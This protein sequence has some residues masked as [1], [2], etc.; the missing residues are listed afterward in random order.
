MQTADQSESNSWQQT[1][2]SLGLTL[3]CQLN[4]DQDVICENIKH[5]LT[6]GLPEIWPCAN[7]IEERGEL[8][9]N[10]TNLVICAGGPS[11]LEHIDEIRDRQING[12][13]I[14]ALANVAHL[15]LAH[16]IRPNAHVL[17]DAKPRNADF[18]TNCETTLFI[19]S[20]CDPKVFE[21]ALKTDNQVMLYHAVNNAQEADTLN[22]H[23]QQKADET[24]DPQ[25]GVWVPVQGGSTITMRAIRLFTLLGYSK[26]HMYGWDSCFL[27]DSHH[28]YEQPDA[29]KQRVMKMQFEDRVFRVT[30]WMISQALE[31][32]NF[33]KMFCMNIDLAV[34][35]EGLIAY[36]IKCAASLKVDIKE[37]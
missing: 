32:Q 37:N 4:T 15:L 21:N 24:G 36:I 11:L 26:F 28:A 8:I 2:E 14:V 7:R 9:E 27:N 23:Y 17:L 5:A 33:V 29:D 35:G 13:K 6:L 3:E 10:D 20:Q 30:P 31:M 25:E 19:S 1:Y 16:D 22:E 34:H 12:A 18:I